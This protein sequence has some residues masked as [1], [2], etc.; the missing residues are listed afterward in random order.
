MSSLQP[1]WMYTQA[2][3]QQQTAAKLWKAVVSCRQGVTCGQSFLQHKQQRHFFYVVYLSFMQCAKIKFPWSSQNDHLIMFLHRG[4]VSLVFLLYVWLYPW[5]E[6]G[7]SSLGLKAF[8]FLFSTRP[9][10]SPKGHSMVICQSA[11]LCKNTVKLAKTRLIKIQRKKVAT[12][13]AVPA[14]T[15]RILI[16]FCCDIVS[17]S[18]STAGA[19]VLLVIIVY[20]ESQKNRYFTVRLT[21]SKY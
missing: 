13:V 21:V 3:T 15:S 19:L 12:G 8:R 7:E 14:P 6:A 4:T 9:H 5:P 11:L 1:N 17:I 16:F 2:L 10:L 18:I 20:R